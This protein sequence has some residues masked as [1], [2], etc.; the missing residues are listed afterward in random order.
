MDAR[1]GN[2]FAHA[3]S[4]ERRYTNVDA[5]GH[6]TAAH[7]HARPRKRRYA[8]VDARTNDGHATTAAATAGSDAIAG[9]AGNQTPSTWTV[10]THFCGAT[11]PWGIGTEIS[12]SLGFQ[13]VDN[14]I[15]T[16]GVISTKFS[17]D[18]A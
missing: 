16:G 15:R 6:A 13:G 7:K 12:G 17:L 1:A 8:H 18:S 2:A 11:R 14:K 4:C 3:E 9:L 10:P 5:N